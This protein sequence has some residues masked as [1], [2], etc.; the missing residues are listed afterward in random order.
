MA[1]HREFES[2]NLPLP[3]IH[4]TRIKD[5]LSRR[6][7]QP[8]I[9]AFECQHQILIVHLFLLKPGTMPTPLDRATSQ[10]V[11]IPL[12]FFPKAT[13]ETSRFLY[14][15]QEEICQFLCHRVSSS[16][17]LIVYQAPFFAFAAIVTGVAAW[18]IWGADL[19]PGQDPKGGMTS[20]VSL[21]LLVI[22]CFPLFWILLPPGV[23]APSR[24]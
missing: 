7:Y 8:F 22:I 18:S 16:I 5:C 24:P 23:I 1:P 20:I 14:S 3:N 6:I 19:F 15:S 13:N 11:S 21:L 12:L 9:Y 2:D 17:I 10:R 4:Y